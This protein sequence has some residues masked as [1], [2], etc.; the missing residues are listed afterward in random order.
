MIAAVLSVTSSP[1]NM[2][3]PRYTCFENHFILF[4]VI[5]FVIWVTPFVK[6]LGGYLVKLN[7]SILCNELRTQFLAVFRMPRQGLL[8]LKVEPE[9]SLTP[10]SRHCH[11]PQQMIEPA[12]EEQ[13]G[14]E[15]HLQH[16][17]LL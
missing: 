12:I 6:C 9:E 14:I 10:L 16:H 2:S 11:L 8:R 1:Q 17:N 15:N 5:H 13:I 7:N 3:S 4:G